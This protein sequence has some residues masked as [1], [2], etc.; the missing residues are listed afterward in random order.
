MEAFEVFPSVGYGEPLRVHNGEALP[1]QLHGKA[2]EYK[3]VPT[4]T[5]SC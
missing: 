3:R 5:T 2:Q 1:K 4:M